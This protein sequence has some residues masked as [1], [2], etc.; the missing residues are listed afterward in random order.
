MTTTRRMR[1]VVLLLTLLPGL[2]ACAGEYVHE[3]WTGRSGEQVKQKWES[4]PAPHRED[5]MRT[6]LLMTQSDH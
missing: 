6:R 4:P 2:A 3:P 5:Q 1:F